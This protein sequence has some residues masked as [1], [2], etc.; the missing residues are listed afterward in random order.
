MTFRLIDV[1]LAEC[2][3]QEGG[4]H[5]QLLKDSAYWFWNNR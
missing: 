5:R 4:P 1:P 2:E 3:A